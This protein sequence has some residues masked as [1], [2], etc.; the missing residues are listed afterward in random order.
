MV[1]LLNLGS[2]YSPYNNFTVH[3]GVK[4]RT[5]LTQR[6]FQVNKTEGIFVRDIR[7]KCLCLNFSNICKDLFTK[8]KKSGENFF[9]F[10]HEICS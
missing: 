8:R 10:Y 7:L 4:H 9:D 6:R 2:H 1:S 5:E 3:L